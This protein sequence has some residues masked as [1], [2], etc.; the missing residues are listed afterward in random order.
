TVMEGLLIRRAVDNA[1]LVK[2]GDVRERTRS[3]QTAIAQAN[4]CRVQRSHLTHRV[5]QTEQSAFARIDAQ[6]TREG[7]ETARV[8]VAATQRSFGGKRRTVG[9]YRTPGLAQGHVHVFLG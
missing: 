9:A 8:R 3:Q 4:L 5:F 1:L 2:D 7:A 6:H